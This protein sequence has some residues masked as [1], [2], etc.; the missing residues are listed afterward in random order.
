[1]VSIWASLARAQHASEN[2]ILSADDAFGLTL[3]TETIGIYGPEGVRGFSPQVAGNARIDG[4]YFDQQGLLSSRVIEGS[5]IRVGLSAIG[6]A[7][8]APT[9]LVDYDLRRPGGN[10]P[11]A[12]VIVD[13]GPADNRSI[14]ID[15]SFPV[16]SNRVQLPI[17]ASYQVAASFPG[18]S[19]RVANFGAAPEWTP[20]DRIKIRAFFDWQQTSDAKT[21]P[22]IFTDG[23]FLPPDMGQRYRGQDWARGKS[24]SENYGGIVNASLSQ[25]WSLA[26]GIFRSI[27]DAPVSYADLYVDTQPS[28]SALHELVGSPD[29]TV[30][31]TSGEVRLTGQ[32]SQGSLRH[33]II[34]LARGRDAMALYGGSAVVAVG[35]ALIGAGMQVPA[36]DFTYSARTHD[37]TELKSLGVAYHG[38]W[39]GIGEVTFGIQDETYK[40]EVAAPG[41]GVSR[42]TTS[43]LRYYG[44]FAASLTDRTTVY[45][46]YTQGL[47]DSGVAP[48]T[49]ENRGA[50]LPAAQTWQVDGGLRYLLSSNLKLI[51][52]LFEVNK[53]YFNLD[54]NTVDRQLGFQ[55]AKGFEFSIAGQITKNL[56][57][58]VG[59]LFG[60][61]KVM[62]PTLRA[63]GVGSTAIGQPHV[64]AVVDVNYSAPKWPAFSVDLGATYFGTAPASVDSM[65]YEPSTTT[66][67]VG[68]RYSFS[69]LGAPASIRV[70]ARNVIGINV[71]NIGYSPGFFQYPPQRGFLAY[72]TIDI[73]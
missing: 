24:L 42:L 61:V 70:Q 36:P 10:K 7:F 66:V 41:Q 3:G 53:P 43:P 11:I 65:V 4:L 68:G 47:E 6:Y 28:G 48:S 69:A 30:A 22:L 19:S 9:G 49:A 34:L 23:D 32:F 62:G 56:T 45:T 50:I 57:V 2:P 51:A 27:S 18:Y 20:N 13:A 25:R 64:Q 54:E 16:I 40:K 35:P 58:N 59:G 46:G 14:S 21:M 38:R 55:R 60:H 15:G 44:T 67:N 37:H 8:P 17:G 39:L 73:G 12:T 63:D 52:G 71:W 33:E 26:V 29:Q 5:T 31:S 1:M 72:L